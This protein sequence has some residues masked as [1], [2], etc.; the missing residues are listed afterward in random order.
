MKIMEIS[1]VR[2]A[3]NKEHTARCVRGG[4]IVNRAW[5]TRTAWCNFTESNFHR[6]ENSFAYNNKEMLIFKIG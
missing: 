2:T 1:A 4:E 3:C 6:S 5:H